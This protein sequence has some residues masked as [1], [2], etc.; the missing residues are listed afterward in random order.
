MP[1]KKGKTDDSKGKKTMT[2][3]EIIKTKPNRVASRRP[4]APREGTLARPGDAL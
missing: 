2:P 4:I 1:S 3:L